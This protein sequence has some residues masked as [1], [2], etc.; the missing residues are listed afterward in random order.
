MTVGITRMKTRS[1]VHNAHVHQIASD[2]PIIAASLPL[3]IA[4]ATTTAEATKP[5]SPR[6][7][8][9]AR[10]ARASATYSLATTETAFREFTYVTATTTVSITPMKTRGISAT[11]ASVILTESSRALPTATGAER[12]AFRRGGFATATRT[13]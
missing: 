1:S 4:M 11:H 12:S 5:T 8:A 2:V 7:I 13:A 9:E 10:N 3:G 6:S